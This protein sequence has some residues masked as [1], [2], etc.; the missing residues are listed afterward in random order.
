MT[1][2]LNIPQKSF[3]NLYNYFYELALNCKSIPHLGEI[4][5]GYLTVKKLR[6]LTDSEH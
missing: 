6:F 1:V 2:N 3:I 4:K 5:V